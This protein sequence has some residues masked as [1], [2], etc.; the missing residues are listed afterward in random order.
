[1]VVFADKHYVIDAAIPN[2][3]F[4]GGEA[5]YVIPNDS[6]VAADIIT[7]APYFDFVLDDKGT[8]IGVKPTDK[9]TP[10]PSTVV[11]MDDISVAVAELAEKQENDKIALE[12]AIAELA[13]TV[14]GS[15]E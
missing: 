1:M 14:V 5:L 3:D 7:Y 10:T 6:I 12:E 13:E 4:T 15:E 11:T 8:L 9:P 2:T